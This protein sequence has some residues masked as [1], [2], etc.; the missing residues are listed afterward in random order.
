MLAR[1]LA[2]DDDEQMRGMLRDMLRGAGYEVVLA[3]AEAYIKKPLKLLP[4]SHAIHKAI[5][6]DQ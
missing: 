3:G 1:V 4:L 6:Q 2:L 5:H